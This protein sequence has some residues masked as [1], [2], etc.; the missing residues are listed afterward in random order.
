[1]EN[2]HI[3]GV[4]RDMLMESPFE[5]KF[6]DDEYDKKFAS[7]ERTG[8]LVGFFAILAVLISCLG[9]FGMASYMVE[10]RTKEI[11]IRK[12]LG[13]TVGEGGG[14]QSNAEFAF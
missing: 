5:Y 7:E 10:Q 13:A 4:I 12:V 1:M 8:K 9:I 2:L 14:G 11:R 3:L 6:V